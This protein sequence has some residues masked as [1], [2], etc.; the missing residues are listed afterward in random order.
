[1][2]RPSDCGDV[3]RDPVLLVTQ[4]YS[5]EVI[6][7]APYCVDLAEGFV[8]RGRP[9]AVLTGLPHYPDPA[10]FAAFNRTAPRREDRA[11][12]VVER[13]HSWLPRKRSALL[14]VAGEIMFLL[15][16]LWALASRRIGRSDIVVSLCPSIFAVLLGVAA[17]RRGGRHVAL[18]HDIQ[19]GL[20]RGLAMV[21]SGLLIRMMRWCERQVLNRVDMVLVLS[22][23]MARELRELGVRAP[24]EVLPI[25]VDTAS[26]VP[27]ARPP[28]QPP[29]LLYS[30]N[31]GRKQGLEQVLSLAE[32][33]RERRPDIRI[34]MRGA[35]G[36]RDQI[37][38]EIARR[39][40]GNIQMEDLL[41]RERLNEAL[42]AGDVHLVPQKPDGAA[43][44]VPS[45]IYSIMAA[46][47]SFVT[48]AL[49]DSVLWRLQQ[50]TGAFLCVP[51]DDTAAMAAAAVRLLDD[52]ALRH[53]MAERGRCHVE[54]EH[55]RERLIDRFD[56]IVTTLCREGAPERRRRDVLVFEP[57]RDG[58]AEEWLGH[59][60]AHLDS[61]ADIGRVWFLVA[62][63]LRVTLDAALPPLL[64]GRVQLLSLGALEWYL[65]TH[66]RLAI[67]GFA[68][69]W[70]MRRYLQKTGAE[71]GHFLA[72]D[73]LTLPLALGLG[74]G[75]RPL[76]GILFRPSVHYHMLGPYRPGWRERLRDGRKDL[77]Y[78][79]ML[80]NPAVS[81]V[82]TLDPFFPD[83][84][85][86]RYGRGDKVQAV[87]D[88]AFPP[89][90]AANDSG[91]PF[92]L[93]A[94]RVAFL[95]FGVLSERK[96]VLNLIDALRLLPADIAAR[97]AI[98]VAG[99]VAPDIR[100]DFALRRERLRLDRPDLW[101]H[102]ENRRLSS[103]E[104]A[105]LVGSA[106]VILAPY[107]RFVGSSGV[108][109]WAARAGKPLLTQDYGLLGRL[110]RDNHL[111]LTVDATDPQ[112]L[113]AAISRMVETGPQHFIDPAATAAF[114]AGRTPDVFAGQVLG[115][116][117]QN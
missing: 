19:S 23:D 112:R 99:R 89:P 7:S 108:L 29:T 81:C 52:A 51:P 75:R 117:R 63:E 87:P 83:Y 64:R 50:D 55:Q 104:I 56:G 76:G 60:L 42:A 96:G 91:L 4:H 45:K 34:L 24:I 110:V 65:C 66:R 71:S 74:A 21:R 40:L 98:V 20:A 90:P 85:R 36:E 54:G 97:S 2:R 107:Q 6:G 70:V 86:D 113:A 9:V 3:L 68:R 35:G 27:C 59:L 73:H 77:L 88:P 44:A 102:V 57:D 82:L 101:L 32:W 41:P 67:S 46:G 116:L 72:L 103:A 105:A 93:P 95:L 58:H 111:G 114:I 94:G 30:G 38:Q 33:L 80:R 100:R 26:I 69:W 5:P 1:M 11:G 16:G 12:V 17:T 31:M 106:D 28:G 84:A 79:L 115:S 22:E 8:R 10:G 18:V 53:G 13:L 61:H 15:A 39:R 14:R 37:A 43:F 25:W 49:P 109:L 48:T 78:R 62:P 92:R 47:R